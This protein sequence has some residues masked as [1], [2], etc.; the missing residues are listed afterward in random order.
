VVSFKR[1]LWG[2]MPF[3]K[4]KVTYGNGEGV[5][6]SPRVMGLIDGELPEGRKEWAEGGDGWQ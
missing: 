6:F 4:S 3:F 2:V 5:L 1:D